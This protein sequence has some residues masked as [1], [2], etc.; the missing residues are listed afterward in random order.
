MAPKATPKKVEPAEML[1]ENERLISL[2]HRMLVNN[3]LSMDLYKSI[4]ASSNT[5]IDLYIAMEH[6]EPAKK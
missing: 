4:I 6:P 3:Q 5:F 1:A 2:A